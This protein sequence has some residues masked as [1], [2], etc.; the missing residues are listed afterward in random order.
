MPGHKLGNGIPDEMADNLLKLD[1]T[2][3]CGSGKKSFPYDEVEKAEK[4][5][6]KTFGADRTFFLVNG[7]TC[8]IHAVIM[9]MCKPKDKLI[10]GRDSHKSVINAMILNGVEPVYIKPKFNKDFG[11]PTVITP[12]QIESAIKKN[13]D[14]AGVIITR[15]NYYGICSDI[16]A[17]KAIADKYGKVLAVDEAHGAH[18]HFSE[19][20]PVSSMKVG[21][22]LCVQSAHKTLPVITQGAYL[23]I[24]GNKIRTETLRDNLDRIVTTSPSYIIMS[25]LDV[26]RAVMESRG[27]KLFDELLNNIDCFKKKLK[28]SNC[29]EVLSKELLPGI[30][31]DMTR[32]VINASKCGM[33]GFELYRILA[34]DFNIHVEMA[35]SNNI[36]CICSVFDKPETFDRLYNALSKIKIHDKKSRLETEVF[37]ESLNVLEQ[38]ISFCDIRSTQTKKVKLRDSKGKVCMKT[39]I[40]YPP[41]IPVI[42]PGEVIT[43][44]IIKYIEK[45]CSLGCMITGIENNMEVDIA[46]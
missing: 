1:I 15:P 43:D 45:F 39:I 31:Y 38:K 42:C 7:S 10:L 17:I 8:G 12:E 46:I 5:A 9:S 4:L 35:D 20:L 22:D 29:F 19:K 25:L 2:E 24:K 41:G 13:P 33:S 18:L 26:A 11:I 44:E 40:P 21:A 28:K 30:S 6:A 14:V 37:T 27:Q 23:H 16:E 34:R 32:M 36:V 3:T